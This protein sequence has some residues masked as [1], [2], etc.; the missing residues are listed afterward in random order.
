MNS[1]LA[2]IAPYY[3]KLELNKPMHVVRT[4]TG[5]G[6]ILT[7]INQELSPTDIIAKF[8]IEPG[9]FSIN[10]AK[11]LSTSPEEA[12]ACLIKKIS[13]KVY[14][15]EL[16]AVKKSLLSKVNL[17]SPTD[18]IIQDYD[19]ATGTLRIKFFPKEI[20]L[21]SGVY[22][23]VD[24]IDKRSG[25]I[26]IKTVATK[27]TA[28]FGI[29]KPRMGSLYFDEGP[30][31]SVVVETTLTTL[32]SIKHSLNRGVSA[33]VAGG[34]NFRDFKAFTTHSFLEKTSSDP[35]ITLLIL[36]GFG[37]LSIHQSILK[38]LKTYSSQYV[39]ADGN[40]L[41]LLLPSNN[42]DILPIL[43]RTALPLPKNGE[44]TPKRL[45]DLK[46]DQLVQVIAPSLLGQTGK[47]IAI[48]KTATVLESGI[49]TVML[50]IET[51]SSKIRVPFQNVEVI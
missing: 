37:A 40:N 27:V 32:S 11:K 2:L 3:P 50:T 34:I 38:I 45:V 13:D 44:T 10:L 36:N 20:N 41:N 49:S 16:L 33:V 9:F 14:K 4:L 31:Q 8:E 26:Y 42:S 5:K 29:G 1:N 39:C 15:G 6:T 46:L 19:K 21:A 30:S 18:G 51:P 24:V 48:D 25:H 47:V 22:G 17:T 23:I 43:R 28:A 35:G 12:Q 7:S